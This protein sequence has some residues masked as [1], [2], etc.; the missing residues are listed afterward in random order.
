MN[1]AVYELQSNA[2]EHIYKGGKMRAEFRGE[3]N[4]TDDYR[5]EDWIFSTNRA[6]TP[7]KDNPIDKGISR[8]EDEG[9]KILLTDLIETNPLLALG[10]EHVQKY[11]KQIGVLLKIFNVAEGEFLP[12][13]W[14]PDDRFAKAHLDSDMGKVEAWY[15]MNASKDAKA[16]IGWNKGMYEEEIATFMERQDTEEI[17][18]E[19]NEVQLRPG[20]LLPIPS[21]VVHAIRGATCILE[22][23]QPTDF[24]V[25]INYNDF[26]CDREEALLQLHFET[27]I[28]SLDRRNF[29]QSILQRLFNEIDASTRDRI[30]LIPYYMVRNFGMLSMK[31]DGSFKKFIKSES[32]YCMTVMEGKGVLM[33]PFK[34]IEVEKGK[35]YF[36]PYYLRSLVVLDKK[37]DDFEVMI[38]SPPKC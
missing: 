13:H 23:Q 26:E 33:S 1:M 12:I 5:S 24:S 36:V 32:F 3:E 35:S 25:L 10:S 21:G 38:T 15:V 22:V 14:H 7:G 17:L 31:F 34:K 28:R 8:I 6:I 27:V 2:I 9:E 37:T 20:T 11:D 30:E 29:D 19:M 16:W 4:P 18:S